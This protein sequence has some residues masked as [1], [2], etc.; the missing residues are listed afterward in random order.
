VFGEGAPDV[1]GS[2]NFNE[3]AARPYT[4]EDIRFTTKGRTLYAFAL[5]W[6]AAGKVTIK[7]LAKG[8]AGYPG[9]VA[10]VELLGS[11]G[12]L[13][14][15]RDTTGLVVNLPAQKPHD[16]AYALKITPA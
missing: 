4:A 3:D 7:T 16:Y 1:K 2:A 15:V 9:E 13:P 5:A 14:F 8:S 12:A 6:P 10:K 11:K